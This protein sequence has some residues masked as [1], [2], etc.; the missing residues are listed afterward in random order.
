M[1]PTHALPANGSSGD[2]SANSS[3][4][5]SGQGNAGA[6]QQPA[7]A[8]RQVIRTAT[9]VV[10]T[11]NV[12]TA[13]ARAEQIATGAGG[14]LSGENVSDD[15]ATV[16]LSVPETQLDGV[17]AAVGKLGK[18]ASQQEQ[19]QDVTSQLVDVSSRIATQ[20]ASVDRVRQLLGQAKSISDVV[21]IEDELTKREADLESMEHQQDELTGQVAMSTVNVQIGKTAPPLPVQA[22]APAAGFGSGI[23]GGWHALGETVRIVLLVLG[24]ALPFLLGIG[25]PAL[26]VWWFVR[27]RKTAKTS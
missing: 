22:A 12:S 25:I 19:S 2:S 6:N 8:G 7:S 26:A 3:G 4:S 11:N 5:P 24:A 14:Y 1:A 27:R 15:S 10:T 16:T 17:L 23:A 21:Q 9:V 18:V 20:Q 13:A